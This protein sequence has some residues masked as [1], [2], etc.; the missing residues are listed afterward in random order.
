MPKSPTLMAAARLAYGCTARPIHTHE[1]E[2]REGARAMKRGEPGTEQKALY[3]TKYPISHAEEMV[4]GGWWKTIAPV[5]NN[6]PLP[7]SVCGWLR[8]GVAS[9]PSLSLIASFRPR[10][11]LLYIIA[12]ENHAVLSG[13][14]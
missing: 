14:P 12:M 10:I 6:S 7:S 8:S 11:L 5:E 13:F 1:V 9:S 3:I 2:R 4:G